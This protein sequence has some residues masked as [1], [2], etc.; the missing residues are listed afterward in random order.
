MKG[1]DRRTGEGVIGAI[2]KDMLLEC[3]TTEDVRRD[4]TNLRKRLDDPKTDNK[5]FA[6]L[7]RMVWEF[8]MMKPPKA[9]DIT[10]KGESLSAGIFIEGLDDDNEEV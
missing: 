9:T 1:S 5:E 2:N 8:A 3:Y 10:S 4:Y 7:L 6:S